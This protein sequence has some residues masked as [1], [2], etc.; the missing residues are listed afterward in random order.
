MVEKSKGKWY[1]G[2]ESLGEMTAGENYMV[3]QL[4][5]L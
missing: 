3:E 1:I 4:L 2:E 5:L